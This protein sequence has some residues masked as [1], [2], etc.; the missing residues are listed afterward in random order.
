MNTRG[1]T[2]RRHH[3][4]AY[5][6]PTQP[7]SPEA[8]VPSHLTRRAA[9]AA[10]ILLGAASTHLAAQSPTYTQL[11]GLF[12]E[13]RAFE[14]PPRLG[15]GVPDYTPATNARRLAALAALQ[16]RLRRI[17]TSGWSI[18]EQ[19]D[20]HLVRAEMNGME[21]HL[22]VLRPFARDPAYYASILTEERDTPA[23][24]GPVIHGPPVA[25]AV[26]RWRVEPRFQE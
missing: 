10:A 14:E 12:A 16:D 8:H 4:L 15:R 26:P 2:I 25:A 5:D 1:A 17:D 19:V 20:R 23:K 11:L 6:P 21:F 18:A 24:E 7:L 13:W 9:L 22:R 3:N